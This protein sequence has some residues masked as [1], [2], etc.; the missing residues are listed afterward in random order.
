ML[1]NNNCN[2]YN[3]NNNHNKLQKIKIS[4]GLIKTSSHNKFKILINN[5]NKML[6]EQL[7][8]FKY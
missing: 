7:I 8:L 2:I 1:S 6:I 4:K 3:S 5:K